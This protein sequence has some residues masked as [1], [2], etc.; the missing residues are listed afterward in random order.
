MRT[1]D[2]IKQRRI[3][4]GMSVEKLASIIKKNKA[5][6]YRYENGDIEKIPSNVLEPLARA[7]NTTPSY[8]LGYDNNK[9]NSNEISNW[10]KNEFQCLKAKMHRKQVEEAIDLYNT[11]SDV[12]SSKEKKELKKL[13]KKQHH[14]IVIGTAKKSNIIK[15]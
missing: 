3:E 12:L 10:R 11:Y 2:R 5:T 13:K 15:E 14:S 6:V 9:N 1:G 7:L 8:L 4:I